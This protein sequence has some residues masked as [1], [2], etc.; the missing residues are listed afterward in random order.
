MA[1]QRLLPDQDPL[2]FIG[3]KP[4]LICRLGLPNP[5]DGRDE[6]VPKHL[7][8][9]RWAVS[10]QGLG[11]IARRAMEAPIALQHRLVEIQQHG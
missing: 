1:V 8:V 2:R 4:L 3:P 5:V 7:S 11:R 6:R 10:A 9:D